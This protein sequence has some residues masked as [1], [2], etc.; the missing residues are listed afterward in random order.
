MALLKSLL[1]ASCLLSLASAQNN[2][3]PNAKKQ[4]DQ[5]S[6]CCNSG[7]W[8][9]NEVSA[10][11]LTEGCNQAASYKGESCVGKPMC[12]S[13][14]ED[15]NDAGVL[16]SRYK[17]AGDPD[18]ERLW[19][20]TPE[21][22]NAEVK[23]GNL[24]LTLKYNEGQKR[25]HGATIVTTRWLQYGTVSARIKTSAGMGVVN[26]FITKTVVSDTEGDEIDFEMIGAKPW[27]VQTNFYTNGELDYTRGN[28]T[29]M[30]TLNNGAFDASSDYHIYTIN[31][32]PTETTW[33]VDGKV[34][35][36][37]SKAT[38]DKFPTANQRVWFSIWDGGC[39]QPQ[40]TVDWA[41]G[42]TAW[43]DN[44]AE[45]S[46]TYQLFVDWL[47]IKCATEDP[48][49]V[50][51]PKLFNNQTGGSRTGGR[52]NGNGATTPGGSDPN[53]A[54]SAK[55]MAGWIGFVTALAGAALFML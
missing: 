39:N 28:K 30:R 10:C 4:C 15:F 41:G 5:F 47:E 12:K 48:N 11:L 43:C 7:G 37:L 54:T 45:R 55:L 20:E 23:D 3:C 21:L 38:S 52:G 1:L 27:E 50:P 36:T 2:I 40:G 34:I 24:V 17:Y 6:P 18:K 46:K 13:Y 22:D 53:S 44:A 33:A 32:T 31:W 42:K 35:R 29:D 25:G 49:P 9:A 26:S 8:C 51:M 14:K 16:V 19:M